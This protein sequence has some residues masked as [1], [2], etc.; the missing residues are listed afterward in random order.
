MKWAS[1]QPLAEITRT[2]PANGL[3]PASALSASDWRAGSR[4]AM[5]GGD[6]TLTY[7]GNGVRYSTRP[8]TMLKATSAIIT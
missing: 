8:K 2:L 3:S 6:A 5:A 4:Q 1:D 7:D